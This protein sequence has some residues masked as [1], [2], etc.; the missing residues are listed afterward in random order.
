L[1]PQPG[2]SDRGKNAIADRRGEAL[3]G[4]I[5][6]RI[7]SKERLGLA[8]QPQGRFE[9]DAVP[10]GSTRH[11]ARDQGER[12]FFRL[13]QRGLGVRNP[14]EL[15]KYPN[16][17]EYLDRLFFGKYPLIE[18]DSVESD[19]STILNV[20]VG[21]EWSRWGLYLDVLNAL[22]SDSHDIDYFYASRLPG[23]A[24]EGV[25][26]IHFHVFPSRSLRASLVTSKLISRGATPTSAWVSPSRPW[27]TS[28][29]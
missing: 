19:G 24:A 18:N 27:P 22:D 17:A 3:A 20:R 15:L 14:I 23:E 12:G 10:A 5:E 13:E 11:G 29:A 1:R 16:A 28:T 2:L 21:R 6:P 26:D 25:E 4:Q 9:I 8:Q 7:E